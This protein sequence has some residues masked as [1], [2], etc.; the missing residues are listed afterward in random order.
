MAAAGLAPGRPQGRVGAN[1]GKIGD[2]GADDGGE[3]ISVVYAHGQ[4][5]AIDLAPSEPVPWA[6]AMRFRHPAA[7]S[8]ARLRG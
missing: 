3:R 6:R 8:P 7:A 4:V 1:P 2:V 5:M